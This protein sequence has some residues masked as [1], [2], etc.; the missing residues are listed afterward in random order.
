[1]KLQDTTPDKQRF[2]EIDRQIAELEALIAA[3]RD[4]RDKAQMSRD[5]EAT[6]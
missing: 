2:A 1:M 5:E 3:W 4:K 6:R